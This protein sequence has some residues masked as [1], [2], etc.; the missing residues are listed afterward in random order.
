MS[1]PTLTRFFK[2]HHC[3]YK[4]IRKKLKGKCDKAYYGCKVQQL[5]VL[6]QQY[7]KGAID[8]YYGDETQV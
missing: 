6:E 2:T 3:A 5:E 8:L 1:Q 4:R 7:S